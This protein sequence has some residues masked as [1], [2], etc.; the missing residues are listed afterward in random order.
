M[1]H[2]NQDILKQRIKDVQG[3]YQSY[4]HERQYKFRETNDKRSLWKR[5]S[6]RFDGS[7]VKS[8]GSRPKTAK[9]GQ[10]G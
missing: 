3:R 2:Y 1:F 9:T 8:H 6:M 5:L 7:R 10:F 4:H